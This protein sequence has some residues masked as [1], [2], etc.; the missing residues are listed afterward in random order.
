MDIHSVLSEYA[1]IR[2]CPGPRHWSV[3]AWSLSYWTRTWSSRSPGSPPAGACATGQTWTVPSWPRTCW[4]CSIRR[5]APRRTGTCR[6]CS[7]WD[8]Q[9]QQDAHDETVG[10][11]AQ[12]HILPSH[13]FH[14]GRL[15]RWCLYIVINYA[16]AYSFQIIRMSTQV[17]KLNPA[18]QD[19]HQAL[20]HL[21]AKYNSS[22]L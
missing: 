19:L 21:G 8:T 6:I 13:Q 1:L 16:A 15:V 20:T 22:D 14:C 3:A 5:T 4:W 7:T 11:A 12:Q 18:K 9:Y 2:H 10:H 17:V